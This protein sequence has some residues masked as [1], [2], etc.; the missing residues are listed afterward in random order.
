MG[1]KDEI[2]S[3]I[4][5]GEAGYGSVKATLKEAKEKYRTI[6]LDDVKH[7]M[8]KNVQKKTQ[9]KGYNSWIGNEPK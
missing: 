6:T 8:N 4:Y 7:W 9:L 1:S 3:N 2:I 5:Y